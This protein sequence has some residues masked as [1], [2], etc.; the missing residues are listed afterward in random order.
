MRFRKPV[1]R[2]KQLSAAERSQDS[3]VQ[4][5]PLVTFRAYRPASVEFPRPLWRLLCLNG[6]CGKQ[7]SNAFIAKSLA[8]GCRRQSKRFCSEKPSRV[9]DEPDYI[10]E[11]QIITLT[12]TGA[13]VWGR[14]RKSLLAL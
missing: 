1:A 2:A 7:P 3:S 6:P 14:K 8:K 13:T 4:R 12:R 10:L 11:K 5:H 9:H